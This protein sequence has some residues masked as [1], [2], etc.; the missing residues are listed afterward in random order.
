MWQKND[1]HIQHIENFMSNKKLETARHKYK[2]H[3]ELTL[4]SRKMTQTLPK[5]MGNVS[6]GR[7]LW[8]DIETRDILRVSLPIKEQ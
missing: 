5:R 7:I 1:Y 4:N 8:V 3:F 6:M 2:K